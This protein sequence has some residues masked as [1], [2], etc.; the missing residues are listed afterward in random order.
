VTNPLGN[1]RL[2]LG[3]TGGI[4]AY[5]SCYLAR[6]IIR[7]NWELQVIMTK[8]AKQFVGPLTF[9]TISGRPVLDCMF[10]DPAPAEPIHLQPIEW[11]DMLIVA[12]ATANF[13][14]KLSHGIADDI[15]STTALAFD[16]TILIAPAMNPRM[17]NSKA[18]QHNVGILLERGVKFIGPEV[19]EMGGVSERNGTGRMSEPIEIADRIKKLLPDD[20]TEDS[21]NE[22][23]ILVTSGPTREPIDPVRFVSNRS[24]GRM[25]DAIAKRAFSRGA[26]V[27][28][29]RGKGATGSPPHGVQLIS[30]ETA[31][32]MASVVKHHFDRSDI[33]IMTAAVADWTINKPSTTKIKKRGGAPELKWRETEDILAWAG[34]NKKQ[35]VVA[36]FALE[37]KNHEREALRKLKD[38]GADLIALNDPT[39]DD[40]KFGG[41]TTRLTFI[42]V[43]SETEILPLMTKSDAADRLLDRVVHLL[44]K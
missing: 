7:N 16:G 15:L 29:V 14:G 26:E 24:S 27:I 36:G 19:G 4:A 38:K 18:V 22:R 42:S 31:A 40:S 37:T 20:P 33:L 21:L 8:S 3:I 13:I 44:P 34:S 32:E 9:A 5:K 1:K 17:W 25:G 39:R 35:Q 6:D 30:I 41:D 28:L 11:G 43:D 23:T 12:P 10:S 2:L